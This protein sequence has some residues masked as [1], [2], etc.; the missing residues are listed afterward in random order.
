MINFDVTYHLYYHGG[1]QYILRYKAQKAVFFFFTQYVIISAE[2]FPCILLLGPKH[3][4]LF[5]ISMNLKFL[6]NQ[7]AYLQVKPT[8]FFFTM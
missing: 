5:F 7:I 1:Y 3:L 2:Y 6:H 4:L 8:I